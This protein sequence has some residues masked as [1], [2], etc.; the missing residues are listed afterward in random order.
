MLQHVWFA[1]PVW[2][3]PNPNSTDTE[4]TNRNDLEI[5]YSNIKETDQKWWLSS[6]KPE[7]PETLQN[8]MHGSRTGYSLSS[9][10]Q[11][12]QIMWIFMFT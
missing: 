8:G 12:I 1:V 4:A 6:G 10:V 11:V 5:L 9:L 3:G 2:C 7:N